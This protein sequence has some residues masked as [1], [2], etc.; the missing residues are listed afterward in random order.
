M[1][2]IAPDIPELQHVP[3]AIRSLVYV[4]ALN[5]AIRSP[6]TWLTGA[7][8]V[9]A[10]AGLGLTAGRALFGG[11]GAVAGTAAGAVV[12]LWVFFTVILP[13]RTRRV[14][15]SAIAQTGGHTLGDVRHADER[16]ERM[17]DAASH[18]EAGTTAQKA[19]RR[20]PERLP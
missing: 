17:I 12:G 7:L 6:L 9:A 14:L 8:A 19:D 4:K 3:E 16:L 5:H 1:S 13:W 15:P 10:G 20:P 2:Q 18:R 11:V